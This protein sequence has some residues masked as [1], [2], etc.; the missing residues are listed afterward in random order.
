VCK[1]QTSIKKN[2]HKINLIKIEFI[3]LNCWKLN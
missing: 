2:I 1:K 3:A